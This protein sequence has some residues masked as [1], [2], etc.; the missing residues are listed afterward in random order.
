MKSKKCVELYRTKSSIDALYGKANQQDREAQRQLDARQL[1][2]EQEHEED[3]HNDDEEEYDDNDNEEEPEGPRDPNHHPCT[4]KERTIKTG[5]P[6]RWNLQDDGAQ[7]EGIAQIPAGTE[8]MQVAVVPTAEVP[9]RR[10]R[11]L[12]ATT[13]V[14]TRDPTN[15][16]NKITP[17]SRDPRRVP[18]ARSTIQ[19][20][21][22]MGNK[23]ASGVRSLDTLAGIAPRR[24]QRRDLRTL[25]ESL[26]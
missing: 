18:N 6:K 20:P 15:R 1:E 8:I 14:E 4:D 16:G 17:D 13:R 2:D 7:L 12:G 21:T 22:A 19:E 23:S 9:L 24:L 11:H 5:W 26:H 3:D 10:G 25:A